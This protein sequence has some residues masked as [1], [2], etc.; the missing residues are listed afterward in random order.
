MSSEFHSVNFHIV[1]LVPQQQQQL[2]AGQQ[3]ETGQ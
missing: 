1:A 2:G 3:L